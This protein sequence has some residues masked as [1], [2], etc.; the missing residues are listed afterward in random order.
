[1][2][3]PADLTDQP[4]PFRPGLRLV[5][6]LRL[7]AEPYK[8]PGST[9]DYEQWSKLEKT[10]PID[11][12]GTAYILT[13]YMLLGHVVHGNIGDEPLKDRPDWVQLVLLPYFEGPDYG[14][15]DMSLSYQL[16]AADLNAGRFDRLEATFG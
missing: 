15:S 3:R 2:E 14:I 1:M 10:F 5:E 12:G 6:T 4:A 11:H 8:W 7:P 9:L 16:P 13:P